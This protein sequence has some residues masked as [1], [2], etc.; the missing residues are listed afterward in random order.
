[1]YGAFNCRC[2]PIMNYTRPRFSVCPSDEGRDPSFPGTYSPS[3]AFDIYATS[4]RHN[5][6]RAS[7]SVLCTDAPENATSS[8]L[9]GG[10]SGPGIPDR[11]FRTGFG[12]QYKLRREKR[13]TDKLINKSLATARAII[14]RAAR[15]HDRYVG[16]RLF[17]RDNLSRVARRFN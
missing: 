14:L 3:R 5:D 1:V 4:H 13:T 6:D 9:S 2:R 16:E 7:L 10:H 11:P 12:L 15:F 8:G 17:N